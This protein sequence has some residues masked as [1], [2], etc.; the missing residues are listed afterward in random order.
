MSVLWEGVL[1]E[2]RLRICSDKK[3]R[4]ARILRTDHSLD[5]WNMTLS[6]SLKREVFDYPTRA[7]GGIPNLL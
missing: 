4:E 2:K 7:L 6:R 1:Y 3:K 5:R